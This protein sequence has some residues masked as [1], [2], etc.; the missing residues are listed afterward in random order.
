MNK[1]LKNTMVVALVIGLS[2]SLAVC[3]A[4]T[5][6]A[7]DDVLVSYL[8]SKQ[9]KYQD[10]APV[11]GKECY[12]LI[13][14]KK[15]A[16][17]AGFNS[18]GTLIDEVNDK[19]FAV[20]LLEPGKACAFQLTSAEYKELTKNW[21]MAVY[22]IDTRGADGKPT[23]KNELTGLPNR[24]SRWGLAVDQSVEFSSKG[25][26]TDFPNVAG[27]AQADSEFSKEDAA[28]PIAITE[29]HSEG[30]MLVA[31]TQ[32]GS[33]TCTYAVKAGSSLNALAGADDPQEGS[34]VKTFKSPVQ[35]GAKAWFMTVYRVK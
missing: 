1:V 34:G 15:N 20:A 25:L 22:L 30:D 21:T 32:G 18:N 19:I 10:G 12:A 27:G 11:V 13:W 14:T 26:I 17:F 8:S 5:E 7:A 23:G 4:G 9:D 31:T 33:D 29:F 35:S 28:E 3:A 6:S 24:V 2:A 16:A